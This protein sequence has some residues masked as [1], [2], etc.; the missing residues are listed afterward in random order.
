MLL[1]EWLS[2]EVGKHYRSIDGPWE[3]CNRDPVRGGVR[4]EQQT[5]GY[6]GFTDA[7][8]IVVQPGHE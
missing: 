5:P 2:F 4:E 6:G 3:G 1:K 7:C 8:D